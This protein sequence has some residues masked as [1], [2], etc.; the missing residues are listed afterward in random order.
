MESK[1]TKEHIVYLLGNEAV[2]PEC[3]GMIR[4]MGISFYCNDCRRT[5]VISDDMGFDR[6]IKVKEISFAVQ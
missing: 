1:K 5:F 6:K 2:C 4:D 3:K